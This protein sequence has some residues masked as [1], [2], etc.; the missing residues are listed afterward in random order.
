MATS[1]LHHFKKKLQ[2]QIGRRDRI[3]EELKAAKREKRSR[4][5]EVQMCEEAN[6]IIQEVA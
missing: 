4:A 1:D 6:V 5:R 3:E 2:Q